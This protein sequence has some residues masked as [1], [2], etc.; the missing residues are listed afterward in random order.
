MVI[1]E[2]ILL[3][4]ALNTTDAAFVSMIVLFIMSFKIRFPDLTE[5][6]LTVMALFDL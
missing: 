1:K 5:E 4:L 2:T 6:M 3:R